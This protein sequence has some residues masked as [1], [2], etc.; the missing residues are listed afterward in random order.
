[1]KKLFN[2]KYVLCLLFFSLLGAC[3]PSNTED[4]QAKLASLKEQ[5]AKIEA[6]IASLENELIEKGVIEKKLHTVSL[7]AISVDTFQHFI[8]LQGR[9]DADESVAV[10]SR[11]P[12]A[13]TRVYI[14]NGD[15]VRKGQLLAEIDG[16]V[17]LKSLAELEGQLKVADDLYKRQKALWDQNI[18]SEV[19]YIQAKNNKESAERSIATLKETW[20]QTRIY[21][22]T[23][24]TVDMVMLKQ[25]QA[26]APGIPLANIINLSKLKVK[27]EVTEAYAAKVQKGDEVLV[28][29]PDM[30]KDV[31]SKITYVSK[32]INPVDR[33]FTVEASLGKG[34]FR[35]NQVAVMKI[36]DY[37][38]L[39]AVTIPV[40]LIQS[41]EDGDYVMIAEKTGTGNE[42]LVKKVKIKQGQNY[43]GYVEVL[44][45]LKEGD[46]IISTGFQDVNEGETV[47]FSI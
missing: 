13:L 8:D 33:T 3:K 19:Q 9:V 43:N 27:G 1:M 26:I 35:A 32:S 12:G 16:G 23:S 36:V 34:D 24:G 7:M 41:G 47:L 6:E 4:P 25:G 28:H 42:A 14:D 45:G 18:G 46:L 2:M 11:M 17:M 37:K 10:T 5:K 31:V 40:N 21:A 29:F 20:S 38:N 15:V 22:P 30:N 39:K 44:E